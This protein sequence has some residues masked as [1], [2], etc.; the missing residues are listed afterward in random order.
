[1]KK[2]REDYYA[3]FGPVKL[4]REDIDALLIIFTQVCEKVSFSDDTHTY[5]SLDEVLSHR[6]ADVP[7]LK[8]HILKPF[9]NLNLGSE[10]IGWWYRN[11]NNSLYVH[12]GEPQS[13]FLFLK[14][15]TCI[16]KRQKIL[17]KFVNIWGVS[18][19]GI[20]FDL[21]GRFI[22]RQPIPYPTKSISEL[23]IWAL[24]LTYVGFF[25]RSMIKGWS[26][27]TLESQTKR[28]SFWSRNRDDIWKYAIAAVIG[29]AI[30]WVFSHLHKSALDSPELSH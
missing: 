24:Y 9:G 28:S 19:F 20:L 25:F 27:I 3:K 12:E 18:V 6:G 8:T 13:E 21:V 22:S 17:P 26:V 23:T 15:R 7:R 30:Q 16:T 10:K 11:E 5:D 1:M 4:S 2:I 14:V 29:G